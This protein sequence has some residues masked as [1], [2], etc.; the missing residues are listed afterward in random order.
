MPA[1]S[2]YLLLNS[3]DPCIIWYSVNYHYKTMGD[4]EGVQGLARV[5]RNYYPKALA[6][7][8]RKKIKLWL[9]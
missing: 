1:V 5:H 4:S 9:S 3:K 8:G 6:I 7:Q 2:M